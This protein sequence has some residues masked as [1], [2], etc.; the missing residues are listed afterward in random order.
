MLFTITVLHGVF[1]LVL[2]VALSLTALIL[3]G[4]FKS[5]SAA[6]A[7][8]AALIS[9][10]LLNALGIY[11]YVFY[12]LA[13][14]TSPR[15]IILENQAWVHRILFESMEYVGLIV[16]IMIAVITAAVVIYGRRVAESVEVRGQINR[17]VYITT[18][19]VLLMAVAGFIPT[20]IA[21]A[22]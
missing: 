18:F 12:R 5:G 16:P 15:S 10:L 20:T 13:D 14:A 22:K 3:S 17:L 1:A 7:S 2:I 21:I 11:S 6:G 8:W 9:A 19:I 4:L